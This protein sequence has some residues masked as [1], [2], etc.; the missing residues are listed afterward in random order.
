MVDGPEFTGSRGALSKI[1]PAAYKI[2]AT[3]FDIPSDGLGDSN[4]IVDSVWGSPSMVSITAIAAS[5]SQLV[6]RANTTAVR[7]MLLVATSQS[8]PPTMVSSSAAK[9]P[10]R[11]PCCRS[12]TAT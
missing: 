10:P 1:A 11:R 7:M 9:P 8:M 2:A 4:S 3:D 5:N 12:N 6:K